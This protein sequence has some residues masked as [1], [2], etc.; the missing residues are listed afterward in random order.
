MAPN[1]LNREFDIVQ[2]RKVWVSDINYIKVKK[3][4]LYLTV[5]LDLFDRKI[6]G[7]AMS[8]GMS[9]EQTTIPAFNMA[10]GNRSF[11]PTLLFHSDRGVQNACKDFRDQLGRKKIIQSISRKGNCWDNAFRRFV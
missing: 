10:I 8:D 5:V 3:S 4:W 9:A 1:I 7:W 6:I 2:P 11:E